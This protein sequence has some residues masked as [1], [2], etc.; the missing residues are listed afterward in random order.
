MTAGVLE[1]L[2]GRLLVQLIDCRSD[3]EDRT[4]RMRVHSARISKIPRTK[5]TKQRKMR[6]RRRRQ[7]GLRL[8]R[9]RRPQRCPFLSKM[10]PN[11]RIRRL[12]TLVDDLGH[13]SALSSVQREMNLPC[14]WGVAAA[15]FQQKQLVLRQK[16]SMPTCRSVEFNLW[17]G[18][19]L[20]R[21]RKTPILELKTDI[22]PSGECGP[23]GAFDVEAPRY[24]TESSMP[25]L[26]TLRS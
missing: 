19:L 11:D 6:R 20:A 17:N 26:V 16:I 18:L 1:H 10:I 2:I 8:L 12:R 15:F 21:S 14:S 25:T 4:C 5:C 7:R 22:L 9:P 23:N 13:E 24:Q 3:T